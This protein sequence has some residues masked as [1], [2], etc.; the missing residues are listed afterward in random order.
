MTRKNTLLNLLLTLVLGG[1]LLVV[2]RAQEVRPQGTLGP[3]SPL[4]T[5]FTYQGYLEKDGNSV[6]GQC[7]FQFGLWD[8]STPGSG[9]PTPRLSA[10]G[11]AGALIP[12]VGNGNRRPDLVN[13]RAALP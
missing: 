4:D 8:A 10:A 12:R 13:I 5:A 1:G 2:V 11:D 9:Q 6:N 7:D 3:Q